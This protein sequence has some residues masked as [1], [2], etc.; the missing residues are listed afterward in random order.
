MF[1]NFK[2]LFFP[3]DADQQRRE[4]LKKELAR[5]QKEF[6][7][8]RTAGQAKSKSNSRLLFSS[9]EKVRQF[10]YLFVWFL[11]QTNVVRFGSTQLFGNILVRSESVN[12]L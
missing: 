12:F 5:C 1:Y 9:L 2:D 4:K 8:S 7:L 6:K 3:T 11:L 10:L